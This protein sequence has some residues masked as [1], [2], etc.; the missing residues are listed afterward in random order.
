MNIHKNGKNF[1]KWAE[2]NGVDVHGMDMD[3]SEV[4]F[5]QLLQLDSIKST[6]PE[7]GAKEES[8]TE[9]PK[10]NKSKK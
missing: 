7:A 6:E 10:D 2:K 8:A 5:E 4:L 3:L 1:K 9:A